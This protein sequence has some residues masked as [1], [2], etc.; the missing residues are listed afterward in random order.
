[1]D[2]S[3][4][5]AFLRLAESHAHAVSELK[6]L[7]QSKLRARDHDPNTALPQALAREERARAA[8]IEWKPD[9]NIE[10]QTK[11]L[12]LVHYLISTKKSLD[13]KEMEELMD[14]IAHFVE[15]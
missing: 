1:M 10:A 3:F 9:S 2:D 12:Y 15:K 4:N 8:L 7:R 11:L 14:S 5:G 13:R 6:M